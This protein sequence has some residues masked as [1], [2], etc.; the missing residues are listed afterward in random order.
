MNRKLYML[1]FIYGLKKNSFDTIIIRSQIRRAHKYAKKFFFF[2][3]FKHKIY[4]KVKLTGDSGNSDNSDEIDYLFI[5][6]IRIIL[7]FKI[8]K[9]F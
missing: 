3:I 9:K 4:D 5:R 1:L 7:L 2:I 6:T 8:V